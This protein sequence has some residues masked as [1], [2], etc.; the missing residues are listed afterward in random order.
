MHAQWIVELQLLRSKTTGQNA[1]LLHT[2]EILHR[3]LLDPLR[4]LFTAPNGQVSSSNKLMG[5]IIL[6]FIP[7]RLPNL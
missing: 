6:P 7:L 5:F 1:G 3:L 2:H 4:R